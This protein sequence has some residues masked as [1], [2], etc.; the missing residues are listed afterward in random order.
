M[1]V[2]LHRPS[3]Q[4]RARALLG[5]AALLPAAGFFQAAGVNPVTI[6]AAV[7]LVIVCVATVYDA[8]RSVATVLREGLLLP[9][10]VGHGRTSVAWSEITSVE[11]SPGAIS[12]TIG[13]RSVVQL[14][15]VER[16]IALLERMV[17]RSLIKRR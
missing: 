8:F 16:E 14:H 15:L 1:R 6:A 9:G 13:S 17:H 11:T 7:V 2:R 5:L 3:H 10:R 12:F 4:R